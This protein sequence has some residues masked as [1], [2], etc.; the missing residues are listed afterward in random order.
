MES[1]LGVG[2]VGIDGEVPFSHALKEHQ[3]RG[4]GDLLHTCVEW[5]LIGGWAR[6]RETKSKPMGLDSGS[7]WVAMS[8]PG[9]K[10]T[11]APSV[12]WRRRP[13]SAFLMR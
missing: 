1:K 10:R 12:G 6:E 8:F 7:W 11:R 9:R 13:C 2:E 3:W 4:E 5:A